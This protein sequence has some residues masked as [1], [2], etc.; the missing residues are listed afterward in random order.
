MSPVDHFGD[1]TNPAIFAR[2]LGVIFDKTSL[3]THISGFISRLVLLSTLLCLLH[4]WT[5]MRMVVPS[6][7]T[8]VVS[9]FRC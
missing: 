3:S 6:A 1:E 4:L 7:E 5:E 9:D 8:D 2:K